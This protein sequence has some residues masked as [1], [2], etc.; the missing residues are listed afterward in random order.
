MK[1]TL[2]S[3]E[4]KIKFYDETHFSCEVLLKEMVHSHLTALSPPTLAVIFSIIHFT[5][6]SD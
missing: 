6:S 3:S 5:P 2:R 1:D 4:L